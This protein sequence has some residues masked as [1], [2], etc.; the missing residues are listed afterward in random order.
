MGL[1][2]I[3]IAP[4]KIDV[5]LFLPL[6]CLVGCTADSE[7]DLIDP[8]QDAT[9]TYQG[10][11]KAIIGT[12]CLG[13]HSSP[14]VNGAPFPLTTYGQ[15]GE[16]AES[17]LLLTAI[18]RQTGELRAMPPPGRLPQ[19]TIDKVEKWIEQGLLEN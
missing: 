17:G 5:L 13:C 12:N 8:Q 4:M 15:V 19:A 16:V 1:F 2:W 14:P 10:D 18:S 6:L 7:G 11:I 3:K 9:V